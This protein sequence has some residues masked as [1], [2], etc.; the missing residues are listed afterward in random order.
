[1][2]GHI[3]DA[4]AKTTINK[5]GENFLI[6]SHATVLVAIE[7]MRAQLFDMRQYLRNVPS[8]FIKFEGFSEDF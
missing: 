7:F 8:Y 1:M 2:T 4:P 5:V 3:I 6:T